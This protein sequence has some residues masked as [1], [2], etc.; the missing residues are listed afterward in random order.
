MPG[1]YDLWTVLLSFFIASLAGFVAFESV[2]HTRYSSRPGRWIS[3]GGLTLGLGI[4][5][6]H[7]VGMNAWRPPFPLYYSL[8]QT[9]V[10]VLVA[11]GAS[12]LAMYVAAGRKSKRPILARAGVALLV[13][14]GI[15]AM[16]FIGMSALHFSDPPVWHWPWLL[17]SFLIAVTAS[18]GA[19]ELLD[20]SRADGFSLELQLAA[21][22]VLGAAICGMHFAGMEAMMLEQGVT[23]LR[24]PWSFS[25]QLLERAGV[26]NAMLF[27]IG[28][29]IVSYRDK[30][31]S[32]QVANRAQL[33]ARESARRLEGVAAAAKIAA[34]VAHEINNPLA[35]VTNLLFLVQMGELG[36]AERG[37]L[38]MAQNEL[39]RIGEI[40]THTLRFYRQ[41]GKPVSTSVPELFDSALLLF[42]KALRHASI[43]VEKQWPAVVPRIV[44]RD[45]EIRQVLTNLV[46]NAIDAMPEGG[47][48]RL[49]IEP[50]LLGLRVLVSDTGVGIPAA[51]KDEILRPFFTT[52][53]FAGTGLGLSISAEIIARHHGKLEFTSGAETGERGSTFV[54]FLPYEYSENS[55]G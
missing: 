4:W 43:T 38:E 55:A 44:C 10:S 11:I 47:T 24:L 7:F 54:V 32:I 12:W 41:S 27:T 35:A 26:G 30:A 18:W 51:V 5:S 14:S 28:L 22:A 50:L 9:V 3:M 16:H 45:G 33:E 40:T 37:Y 20:R 15:C 49:G 2:G 34:S 29:L 21:S 48:L 36:E 39:K 23:C 13:G 8:V 25:G 6:M 19:M 52:K 1:H 42:Q 53:G 17:A 31:V 46:S